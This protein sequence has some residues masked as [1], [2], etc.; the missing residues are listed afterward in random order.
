MTAARQ[1]RKPH[2]R[3]GAFWRGFF[4]VRKNLYIGRSGDT[5]GDK[6][7]SQSAA[8]FKAGASASGEGS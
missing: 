7:G 4:N 8:S 3:M 1:F 2:R 6:S 5:S